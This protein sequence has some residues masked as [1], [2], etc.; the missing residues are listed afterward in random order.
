MFGISLSEV[1]VALD[2][3]ILGALIINAMIIG[4]ALEMLMEMYEEK[5]GLAAMERVVGGLL[6]WREEARKERMEEFEEDWG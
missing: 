6:E 1:D 3:L 4:R 5:S 2:I